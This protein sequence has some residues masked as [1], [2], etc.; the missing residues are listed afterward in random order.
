MFGLQI[1]MANNENG[2][3][4]PSMEIF[5]FFGSLCIAYKVVFII[6]ISNDITSNVIMSA[7]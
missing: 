7:I 1:R 5:I 2:S 4:I 6:I 3:I